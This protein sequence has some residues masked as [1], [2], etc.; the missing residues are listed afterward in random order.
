[1][2]DPGKA[3]E[4]ARALKLTSVDCIEMGI[5]DDIVPEPEQGAHA[6]P[7]EAARLLKRMLMRELSVLTGTYTKTL[8]RRRQKKFR[9]VGEYGSRFRLA[10]R[11]E[12][13]A[14]QVG[15][16][17]GVRALRNTGETG[18]G[19]QFVDDEDDVADEEIG[20]EVDES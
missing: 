6:S 10:L 20:A 19:P 7:N 5:V 9:K 14:W 17:A 15:L 8:V 16:A 13:K 18:S 12:T 11:R 1:M 2:S 4:I 3:S